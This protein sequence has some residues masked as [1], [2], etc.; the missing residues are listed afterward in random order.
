M[1][2][3]TQITARP[4]NGAIGAE[5]SGIDLTR[6]IDPDTADQIRA[7]L[8]QHSVVFIRE[9]GL[10]PPEVHLNL[11]RALGEIKP[12]V[13]T[14][15]NLADRGYPPRSVSSAPSTPLLRRPPPT[16]TSTSAGH[17]PR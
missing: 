17:R 13:A 9:Q 7:A 4:L 12:P 3:T 5:L 6:P 10:D 15:R 14:L 2:T 16:G 8:A 1:T 11:G